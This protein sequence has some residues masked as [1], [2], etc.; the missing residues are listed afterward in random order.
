MIAC[1]L[2]TLVTAAVEF[3][4]VT[5]DGMAVRG[6]LR[7]FTADQLVIRA[8]DGDR[9]L[10]LAQVVRLNRPGVL[11]VPLEPLGAW[12]QLTDGGR[13]LGRGYTTAAGTA[14]IPQ[15]DD[16]TLSVPTSAVQAVRVKPMSQEMVAQWEQ[17]AA[18][19]VK[20]DCV[21]IREENSLDYLEGVLGD[22]GPESFGF[23]LDGESLTVKRAKAEGLIYFHARRDPQASTFC[24]VI[25]VLGS[26]LNVASASLS[27]VE[28]N[29]GQLRMQTTGGVELTWPLDR[30]SAIEFPAQYLS[31][32][33]PESV[34]YTPRMP[35]ATAIAPSV[36]QFYRPKFD[37]AGDSGPL[38][39]GGREYSRGIAIRSRT[40][41]TFL[42]P[43][44]FAKF[45]ATAGIDDRHRPGGNVRLVI[46]GDDRV[47]FEQSI[48]G[49]D[50]PVAISLDVTGVVRLKILVD[51]GSD[52]SAAGDH[53]DLCDPRLFK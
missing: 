35:S 36:S 34:V 45:T 33:K 32:F 12:V 51:Y 16:L 20:A 8:A 37:R 18:S 24:K 5:V 21:V 17:I 4:A 7:E 28:G 50:E 30:L 44:P 27:V 26:Q 31:G 43:E 38:R 49:N 6:E 40:E 22:F 1:W 25:D 2:L 19:A 47:L 14:A 48:T 41:L 11:P 29:V 10:P 52:V 9:T 53:L 39:M 23:T 3:E 13:L 15:A 46:R 42:L